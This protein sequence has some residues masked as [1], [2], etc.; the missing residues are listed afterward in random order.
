M[1]V[2]SACDVG[3]KPAST[4]NSQSDKGLFVDVRHFQLGSIY[5]P[6]DVKDRFLRALTLQEDSARELLL[7]EAQV[8]RKNTEAHV[9]LVEI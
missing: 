8:I 2:F 5:I 9:S 4:C 7:Q 3:C 6:G 1:P